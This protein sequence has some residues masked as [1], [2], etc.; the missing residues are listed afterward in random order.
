MRRIPRY[1]QA[2]AERYVMRH[3]RKRVGQAQAQ[4]ALAGLREALPHRFEALTKEGDARTAS[5]N[6]QLAWSMAFVAGAVN[7]GGFLAVGRYTSH[8]TGV[9]SSLADD[10][11]LGDF[12]TALS[13]LAMMLCFLT[14][15]ALSTV[16]VAYGK[17]H[18]MRSR[19]ALSLLV[20]SIFLLAFGYLGGRLE[21]KVHF[22]LPEATALLCFIMGMHN[23]VT[24]NIS[25]AVVRTTHMT[26]NVTDLGIELA[27]LFYR[28]SRK[29]EGAPV[30][31]ADRGR[32]KLV[33]LLL[34]S[35]VAGGILG[36]L[37]FRHLGF[38]TTVPL[39]LFLVL[40]AGRPLL[41][42]LRLL[43]RHLRR[44]LEV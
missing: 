8:M 29:L 10:A 28:N 11:A 1:L 41:L 13:F 3:L 30:I 32:L 22:D 9:V 26:G 34:A 14:G 38:K 39:A 17:R 15:A 42:E 4:A 21:G 5:M 6:R 31:R 33:V 44:D 24:T 20:E 40:L 12:A 18:R 2:V 23:A 36:A 25:G 37:G 16:L 27:K 43:L 35:F 7:A 19:Y